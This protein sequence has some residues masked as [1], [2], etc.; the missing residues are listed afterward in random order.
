M[1]NP[2]PTDATFV[3]QWSTLAGVFAISLSLLLSE[4]LL[5]RIFSVIFMYH[6]AFMVISLALFGLGVGGVPF[7]RA[8]RR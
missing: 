7:L 4:L 6:F 3:R 5:T 8:D 1:S 2:H